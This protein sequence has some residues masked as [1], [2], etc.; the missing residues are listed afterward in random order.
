MAKIALTL[1]S[2]GARGYAHIG[3]I[4][5]L[6]ARGHE[7]VAVSGASMGALVGGLYATGK[8]NDFTDWSKSLTG[9]DVLRFLDPSWNAPGAVAAD[10]IMSRCA[11]IA[12][13]VQIQDLPIP[14]TIVA[15]D[16]LAQREVW[17]QEGPLI[18]AIRASIAIP[19]MISPQT[20]NGRVLVDGGLLNPVPIEP[21]AAADADFRVAVS[22]LGQRERQSPAVAEETT[23]RRE[24]WYDKVLAMFGRDP[25]V[26]Q[27][28]GP[29]GPDLRVSDV[30]SLSLDAVQNLVARY[31]SAGFPPDLQVTVPISAART[32]DFHRASELIELGRELA[33]EAF[34]GRL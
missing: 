28:K 22:L 25:Q 20:I 16:L 23:A 15:T 33:T 24:D 21:T 26:T 14:L 9:F 7:I 11:E 10:K 32:V 6:T 31:R 27:E 18:P 5:E 30:T 1:G 12:G 8:L 34:D 3:V 13:E 2:G 19:G 29:Q 17:L 4:E